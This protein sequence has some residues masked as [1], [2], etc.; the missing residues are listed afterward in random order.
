MEVIHHRNDCRGCGSKELDL[1][2]S[3]KPS[4]IGDAFVTSDKLIEAQPCYPIDLHLCRRCGLAQLL[5]VIDAGI[6]Y[7][8][9]IYLTSSSLG[10]KEH[11]GAYA[12]NVMERCRLSQNALVID[13]G[14]ND[15]TLL[16]RFME[17]GMRVLG[18]EPSAR[19]ASQANAQGIE[20]ID[21]FFSRDLAKAISAKYGYAKV[22][23]ANNVFANIDDL[24]GWVDAVKVLLD[25]DG[26]FVFESFYLADLLQNKV[27]DFIYHEHLSAFSVKPIEALFKRVG[28]EL[29]TIQRVP[30]KGGSLRYFVQRSGGP[31][32]ND[33]A[34]VE[35]LAHEEN[36]GLYCK[37]TYSGFADMINSLKEKT[38]AFLVQAKTE[39]KSIVGFGASITGTTLIH[40]FEIGDCLDFLVDDN[41]AKQGRFSPGLHL[42]V[43]AVSE[44][45]ERKP[46]YVVI[47]AW[48]YAEPFIKNNRK[49]LDNGGGFIIPVPEFKVVKNVR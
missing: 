44:L 18:V 39:G 16:R 5:D 3:L 12:D 40:H 22:I 17:H 41:P 35:L 6:L 8:D 11:F 19:I 45:Y 21:N 20:T 38:R 29:A 49:Y 46:D 4:P 13:I 31:L 37:N 42:P 36:I 25:N 32:V 28:L 47:L 14:S 27:F 30:T 23:T 15:G 7:G 48:R 26:V 10:L 2:F 34:V 1:V 43:L 9:Y 24:T 33:G